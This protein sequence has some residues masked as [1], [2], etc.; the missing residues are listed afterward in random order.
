[1]KKLL[2][3]IKAKVTTPAFKKQAYRAIRL[4]AFT[5]VVL[6][7]GLFKTHSLSLHAL[8]AAAVAAAEVVF[9]SFFPEV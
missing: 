4:F 9:R 3:A 1:M 8:G 7:S 5:M 6:V 2:A